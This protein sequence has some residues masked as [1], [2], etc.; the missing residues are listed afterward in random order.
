MTTKMKMI[1]L[2]V[3][4]LC[5]ILFY[6]AC[7]VASTQIDVL[8]PAAV[9]IN[10]NLKHVGILNRSLIKSHSLVSVILDILNDESIQADRESSEYCIRGLAEKLNQ[11]PRFRAVVIE[12]EMLESPN[13]YRSSQSISW[14]EV[15]RICK[16][17][18]LDGLIVLEI[19]DSHI[20]LRHHKDEHS[21]TVKIKDNKTQKEVEQ[22]VKTYTYH[23]DLQ[24]ETESSWKIYDPQTRSIPDANIYHE[25]QSHS[26]EGDSERKAIKNLPSKQDILNQIGR[27]SGEQYGIRISPNW[28]HVSRQYYVKGCP[29]FKQ[30]NRYCQTGDWKQAMAIWNDLLSN[31][32]SEIAGH[33]A[34]NLAIGEE[35]RGNFQKAFS[36]AEL[37]YSKYR[38]KKAYEYM[39]ILKTRIADNEILN[40][41]LEKEEN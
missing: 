28:I 19:F 34:F 32:K 39:N 3:V 37:A 1:I 14:P 17:Y 13:R 15:N 27:F 24:I 10:K 33:A 26:A 25:Q 30:A 35:I 6:S 23:V 36:W 2:S 12:G 20:D 29:E 9:T 41:Q 40:D 5:S 21:K 8:V 7:S 11:S 4:C 38:I 22:E 16:K 31:P 18:Q